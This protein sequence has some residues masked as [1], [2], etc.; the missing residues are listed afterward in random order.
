MSFLGWGKPKCSTGYREKAW[1]ETRMRWLGEQLGIERLTRCQVVLPTEDFFPDVYDATPQAAGRL[2]DRV[3]GYMQVN[4]GEISVKVFS[5]EELA[6]ID[7]PREINELWLLDAQLNDPMALTASFATHAAYYLL[8]QRKLLQGDRGW[9]W[10]MELATVYFGMGVFVANTTIRELHTRWGGMV[11]KQGDAPV[12]AMAYALALHAWL[13]GD[14]R[15]DWIGHLRADAA[16]AFGE[17]LRYLQR[18]EDSLLRPDNLRRSDA[19]SI[20]RLLDQ[21]QQQSPSARVAALWELAQCGIV[22]VSPGTAAQPWSAKTE[23]SPAAGQVDAPIPAPAKM[24][25]SPSES[26]KAVPAVVHCLSDSRPGIRAEAARTLAQFG[27]AAETAIHALIDALDDSEDEVRATAA[28]A[29][30]KLAADWPKDSYH[31]SPLPLGEG[32]GVR[33]VGGSVRNPHLPAR[34]DEA[35]V[36][37]NGTVPLGIVIESLTDHL[38]DP[39]TLDTVAWSLAQFAADARPALPRLLRSL[40]SEL[41]RCSPAIDFLVYAIRAISPDPETEIRELVASCDTDV[42]Q[43]ADHLLPENTSLPI[44]RGGAGWWPW[45]DGMS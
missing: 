44:P 43:Q 38:D 25:L 40:K 1:V 36:A 35:V 4:P 28:F 20:D 3:C 27:P 13:R 18:T 5:Q 41:G 8:M 2:L 7:A 37:D 29:L 30:G 11:R 26:A 45:A 10:T 12:R 9:K 6:G 39:A 32:Q 23:L 16:T 31:N 15:P 42:Q 17:G 14:T 21:L 22:P 33:A 34:N 19:N 24:R